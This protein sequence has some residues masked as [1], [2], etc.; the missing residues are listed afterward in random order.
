[1]GY[2][3]AVF[4]QAS[5]NKNLIFDTLADHFR[6]GPLDDEGYYT[7]SDETYTEGVEL[8]IAVDSA[9]AAE[10][11]DALNEWTAR[12]GMNYT[13][14]TQSGLKAK[15]L[16]GDADRIVT[17]LDV[18]EC[19]AGLLAERLKAGHEVRLALAVEPGNPDENSRRLFTLLDGQVATYSIGEG[20]LPVEPMD[21]L[22][23]AQAATREY[24]EQFEAEHGPIP[25]E[26]KDEA[27]RA[28]LEKIATFPGQVENFDLGHGL[29]D[30]LGFLDAVDEG[31]N[32]FQRDTE[33]HCYRLRQLVDQVRNALPMPEPG[34]PDGE[35]K[36]GA[37]WEQVRSELDFTP[38]DEA[39]IKRI[40]E[41]QLAEQ[42]LAPIEPEEPGAPPPKATKVKREWLDPS[43]NTWKP[44]GR[45][46]PRKN[47]Q[48]RE[49]AA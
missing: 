10:A 17:A 14:V 7:V 20:L 6:F 30:M 23:E 19:V 49:V 39:E 44:I 2:T 3:L 43:D 13:L 29:I 9:E 33:M 15:N 16:A 26:A 41:Q 46:R 34:E 24:V 35:A 27:K 18:P 32:E 25:Q 42:E 8:L 4:G 11:L 38:E 1:M 47:V 36:T 12:A 48:I 45:G 37:S 5:L 21:Y 22:T 31:I 28:L 40:K